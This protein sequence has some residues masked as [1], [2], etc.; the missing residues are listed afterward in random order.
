MLWVHQDPKFGPLIQ[1]FNQTVRRFAPALKYFFQITENMKYQFSSLPPN[2][3]SL[4]P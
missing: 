4:G 2:L 1:Y 3:N